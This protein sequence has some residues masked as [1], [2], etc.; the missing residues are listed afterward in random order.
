[1]SSLF[2]R[3][4]LLSSCCLW[5]SCDRSSPVPAVVS[6]GPATT[7]IRFVDV[8]AASN[9]A[10][11]HHF[12][13]G[14]SGSTYRVNPY[15]HGSGLAIADFDGDGLDDVYFCDF[16]GPNALYRNV[17]GMKFEDVTARAGVAVSDKLS[18]GAAF[19]DCDG[20]GDADLYVTTYRGGNVL[21]ANNGDGTFRDVTATAGVGYVGHSNGATWFDCDSDG[22]LDLYLCN[23]GRFTTDTVS[24]EA[25]YAFSGVALP[26][27]QVAAA[28]D[29]K[30][31]GEADILYVN[32]G[33]GTFAD[34]TAA[35]GIASAEWNGDATVSDIDRD[36]DLDLY[37]SNMFGANHLFEN[38]G[39]GRFVEITER[40]GRTSWGGMGARFFDGNDDEWPDLYVVDMHSDMW[41]DPDEIGQVVPE[42]KF[43]NA[44]GASVGGGARID[45][46]E[47]TQSKATLF[48]NTFFE[49]AV[50]REF[51]ES[52]S[53]FGL[54]SW[55]P[56]GIAVGDFDNDGHEDLFVSAGMGYPF[57]YWPNRLLQ[58]QGTRFV[59]VALPA[60]VEP[61]LGGEFLPGRT[62]RGAAM[63][64]SSR[65]SATADFDGDGDLDLVVANF[66]G[67]PYLFE[68]RS[69]RRPALRLALVETNGRPS[70][71]ARV[72]VAAGGRSIH[73]ELHNA[74]G[75][76]TQSSAVLHIGLGRAEKVE[77]L[78]VHYPGAPRPVPIEVPSIDEVLRVVRP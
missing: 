76:L 43:N 39:D 37:T 42:A 58:K 35:R 5:A 31:P 6:E 26:F 46:S 65:A 12:L 3:L 62:I 19:G 75:Y 67:P 49:G 64:K 77:R 69:P 28:P 16:L 60:G 73:R 36:G 21:F 33:D 59:D 72:R 32:R 11:S 4:A 20:D 27:A 8:T 7:E 14:E 38:Q 41:L 61:P 10:F 66:N 53:A 55:W 24:E 70:F 44:L 18:V 40:L 17:G 52:S 51:R 56:W 48:G 1:M 30:N 9:I 74:G 63:S 2:T 15:D 45:S 78:E 25:N 54:E 57:P 22:D 34:E 71:G 47:Q 68:N 29:N 23:I 50:Q 13:D